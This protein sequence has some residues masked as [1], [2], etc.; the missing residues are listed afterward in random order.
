MGVPIVLVMLITSWSCTAQTAPFEQA[1]PGFVKSCTDLHGLLVP[2]GFA[3]LVLSFAFE[4]YSGP[5]SPV[6]LVRFLIKVFL[7]ALLIANAHRL[8][9]D[10]QALVTQWTLTYV[11]ARPENV[12]A[13]YKEKLA[14]AQNAPQL[15]DRNFLS[16]FFSS[17]V[18]EAIIF[19]LLTLL[20]WLAMALVWFVYGVQRAILLVCWVLSPVL[21]ATIA[22]RPVSSLGVRHLFRIIGIVLWPLGLALAATFT[23]GLIDTA[24]DQTFLASGSAFGWLGYG[25]QNLLAVT[26]IAVWI[27]FSTIAAPAIIQ[28]L[29][30]GT[31]GPATV[32]TSAA[33][34]V[35]DT[36]LPALIGLASAR[37][38]TP[39][40]TTLPRS[41]PDRTPPMRTPPLVQPPFSPAATTWQP[42]AQDPVGDQ[43]VRGIVDQIN[44]S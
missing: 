36:G 10:G 43:Q 19:A 13:R 32:L 39:A 16:T 35:T 31:P 23:D 26:V 15:R 4:F 33:S 12:A 2:W 3:L 34:L 24:T 5:T 25:L 6:E 27:I 44:S 1:F 40:R 28:R 30:A 9:N 22:I 29:I 20:A 38:I 21:F 17:N 7:I 37:R 8:I 42:P 14:E 18:F 41:G 11:P